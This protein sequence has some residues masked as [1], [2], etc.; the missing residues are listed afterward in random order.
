MPRAVRWSE[1]RQLGLLRWLGVPAWLAAPAAIVLLDYTLWH[2]HWLNHRVP[3]LW[4]FHGA[5]HADLDLDAS[6]A[7]R[8]HPGELVFSVPFRAAQVVLLGVAL[9]PLLLWETLVFIGV[10]FHHS[11]LRLPAR[12]DRALG[13]VVITPRIHGIHHS[14]RPREL[15]SNFGTLLSI[16]DRLHGLRIENVPQDSIVIGLPH[17]RERRALGASASLSLPFARKVPNR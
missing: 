1:T 17:Q 13:Y 16:W 14:R 8:F 3:I 6:T 11:N 5:H 9:G 7:I 2:W 4:R 10:Q 15:H 12:L